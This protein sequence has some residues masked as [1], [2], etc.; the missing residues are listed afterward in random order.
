MEFQICLLPFNPFLIDTPHFEM[1]PP[2]YHPMIFLAAC[3]LKFELLVDNFQCQFSM[4]A[5]IT[6]L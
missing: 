6:Y 4:S 2:K 5:V 1:I 3:F